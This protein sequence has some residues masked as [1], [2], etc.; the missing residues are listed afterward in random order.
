MYTIHKYDLE[1]DADTKIAELQ[2][3]EGYKVVDVDIQG[4]DIHLWA[5]VK[6]PKLCPKDTPKTKVKFRLYGTGWP[7]DI[8]H[9]LDFDLCFIKTVHAP[10]YVWHIFYED[11]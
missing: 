9:K 1:F 5:L 8:K 3:T 2:L 10:P 6:D 7:L 11:R 4:G